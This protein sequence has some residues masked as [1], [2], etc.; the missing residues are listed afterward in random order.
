[1]AE[2]ESNLT[3][4]ELTAALKDAFMAGHEQGDDYATSYEHGSWPSQ[5]REE[6]FEEM[7]EEWNSGHDGKYHIQKALAKTKG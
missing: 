5:T 3:R 2:V 1:M 7:F 6:A 4:E